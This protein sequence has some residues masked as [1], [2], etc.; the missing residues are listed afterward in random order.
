[1]ARTYRR[2]KAKPNYGYSEQEFEFACSSWLNNCQRPTPTKPAPTP[3][4]KMVLRWV[5]ARL[6][7]V[8][9]EERNTERYFKYLDDLW[10]WRREFHKTEDYKKYWEGHLFSKFSL[11]CTNYR[12]YRTKLYAKHHSDHGYKQTAYVPKDVKRYINRSYKQQVKEQLHRAARMDE[13]D[14]LS[15]PAAAVDAAWWWH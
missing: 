7:K 10:A 8:E 11:D 6:V 2:K 4:T 12:D 5:G 15:I 3:P 9:V 1:M 13:W 14:N